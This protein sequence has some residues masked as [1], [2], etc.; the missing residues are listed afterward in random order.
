M[1]RDFQHII[2]K[3]DETI[4]GKRGYFTD[5]SLRTIGLFERARSGAEPVPGT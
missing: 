3:L 1:G 5:D 2:R 4:R